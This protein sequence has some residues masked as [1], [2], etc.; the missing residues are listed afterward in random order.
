[1]KKSILK[2]TTFAMISLSVLS[3]CKKKTDDVKPRSTTIVYTA[4]NYDRLTLNNQFELCSK[5]SI[6]QS[7][8]FVDDNYL[9]HE[10]ADFNMSKIGNVLKSDTVYNVVI[11]LDNNLFYTKT[12]L[13][14]PSYSYSGYVR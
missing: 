5:I 8:Y 6:V 12:D 2:I 7:Q 13:K 3:S 1:M 14:N 9:L 10:Y 11:T 4:S